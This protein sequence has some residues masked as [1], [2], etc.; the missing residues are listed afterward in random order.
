[1]TTKGEFFYFV[2]AF[3]PGGVSIICNAHFAEVPDHEEYQII[4]NHGEEEMVKV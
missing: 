4:V 2:R 3:I 1:M